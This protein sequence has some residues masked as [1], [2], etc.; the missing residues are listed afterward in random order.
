M[1]ISVVVCPAAQLLG[2][3]ALRLCREPADLGAEGRL[4]GPARFG[5]DLGPCD[6]FGQSRPGFGSI[7]LLR[8]V[9]A[10]RDYQYAVSCCA[11]A[12]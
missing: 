2:E 1:C 6:Q 9:L 5:N 4:A 11:I 10:G 12:H 3:R 7:R 8:P